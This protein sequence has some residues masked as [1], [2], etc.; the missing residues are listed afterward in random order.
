[1]KT[2]LLLFNSMEYLTCYKCLESKEIKHFSPQQ[3]VIGKKVVCFKC[4]KKKITKKEY[5]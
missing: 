3:R 1:M 5:V 2:L 4:E